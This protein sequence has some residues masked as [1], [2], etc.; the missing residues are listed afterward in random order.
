MK[1]T[2]ASGCHTWGSQICSNLFS[3]RRSYAANHCAFALVF[4]TNKPLNHRHSKICFH[5]LLRVGPGIPLCK[6]NVGLVCVAMLPRIKG[7]EIVPAN[8]HDFSMYSKVTDCLSSFP[9]F[10]SIHMLFCNVQTGCQDLWESFQTMIAFVEEAH[11]CFFGLPWTLCDNT[12]YIH[13]D[14]V[15]MAF[16]LTKDRRIISAI[17]SGQGASRSIWLCMGIWS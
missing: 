9:V 2:V 1:Q 5:F 6:K 17:K 13:P 3:N 7:F 14:K 8:F 16:I 12:K 11:K 4:E 15:L 10:V